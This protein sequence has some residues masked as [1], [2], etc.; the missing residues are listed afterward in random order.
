MG[1][2]RPVKVGLVGTGYWAREIHAAGV[3]AHPDAELVGVWGRD[4]ARASA[5]AAMFGATSY[6]DFARL[7]DAVDLLTFAVPPDVQA[8]LALQAAQA[9]RDLLLEKPV[10]L[11]LGD[12]DA[13]LDACRQT[14]S[15][16]VVFFTQRFVPERERWLAE[17]AGPGCLGARATWLASL[18]APGNPF[19]A[20]PWRRS[21]GALWDVGPHALSILI[22]LLG[23][24]TDVSGGRGRGDLVHLV[25]THASG[26]V[27]TA[28]LSLTVPPAAARAGVE[29][30]REDGWHVQPEHP[31]HA[32]DAYTRA[33]SALIGQGRDGAA[34]HP[35]DV[36]FG[37]DVVSVLVRAEQALAR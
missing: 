20:S 36:A 19:D 8:A 29:C 18:Q 12:A 10:A 32:V 11:T 7:I 5:V 3:A 28:A 21:A 26:S 31:F 15:R 6:A 22:P 24:V 17:V 13:L 35:C 14:R 30:Y 16:S 25:L 4:P 1:S 33:L 2:D 37:R 27:S 34:P 23:P 9:G